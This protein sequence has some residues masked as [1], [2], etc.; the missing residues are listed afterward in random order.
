[1]NSNNTLWMGDIFPWMTETFI[2][3]SFNKYEKKP[4][5]IKLI[6]DKKTNKIK[7]YCFIIFPNIKKANDALFELNGKPIINT[8]L[9]FKLNWANYNISNYK[10][11]Y[12]ENLKSDVNDNE[13][14]NFFK[15]KYESVI[16]ANV[17]KENGIS[18]GYGIILFKNENEYF[19]C[20]NEMNNTI[21][22]G[23]KIQVKEKKKKEEKDFLNNN[24]YNNNCNFNNSFSTNTQSLSSSSSG[25]LS[26][27]DNINYS[28]NFYP[29][30]K[31]FDLICYN[32]TKN[33]NNNNNYL[34]NSYEVFEKLND[35]FLYQKIKE[36][37]ESMKEHYIYNYNGDKSKLKCKIFIYYL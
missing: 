23:N 18:Q 25:N 36:S 29:K 12:V 22:H 16:N 5:S 10:S 15:K 3:D 2:L 32:N 19:K 24:N 7:N 17:I 4:S 31:N 28:I 26:L 8:Q 34:N 11:L 21:F 13:L 35:S 27:L 30:N 1:M 9:T 37:I 6:K 14:Y 20:L 33:N